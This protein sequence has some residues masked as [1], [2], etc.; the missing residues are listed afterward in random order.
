M[1]NIIEKVDYVMD[2]FDLV[3][4]SDYMEE[5][6]V[7]MASELNSN[8]EDVIFFLVNRNSQSGNKVDF[9][10]NQKVRS[11]NRADAALFDRANETFWQKVQGK[12]G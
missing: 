3:M 1:D 6:L 12:L 9:K 5:S 4:I 11:W 7:L 10:R 2:T 8:L